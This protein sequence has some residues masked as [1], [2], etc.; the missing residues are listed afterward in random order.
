MTR[1]LLARA[2]P[3]RSLLYFVVGVIV[4]AIALIAALTILT[5]N[6]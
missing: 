1:T 3:R 4:V 5:A 2:A 6:R